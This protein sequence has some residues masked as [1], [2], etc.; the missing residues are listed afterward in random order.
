MELAG[1]TQDGFTLNG[2]WRR[3]PGMENLAPL[4]N[5]GEWVIL[6]GQQ[7]R[8]TVSVSRASASISRVRIKTRKNFK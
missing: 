8:G 2:K 7:F 6:N 5:G 1:M 3:D 4:R